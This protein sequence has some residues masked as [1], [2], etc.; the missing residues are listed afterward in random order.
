MNTKIGLLA[1]AAFV[2][3]A[4]HAAAD[5]TYG[6]ASES[7]Y[8]DCSAVSAGTPCAGSG[9]GQTIQAAVTTG[10][11]L[12]AANSDLTLSGQTMAKPFGEAGTVTV[13]NTGSYARSS[14]DFT[15]GMNLPTI[16]ASTF[17][18][19]GSQDRMNINTIAYQSYDY[20]GPTTDFALTA[21]LNVDNAS[22]SGQPDGVPFDVSTLGGTLPGGAV[23]TD[24]V[25]IWDITALG[26]LT[27]AQPFF[28]TDFLAQCGQTGVLSVG[29]SSGTLAAGASS[30]SVSTSLCAGVPGQ[31]GPNFQIHDGDEILVVAGLQLPVD[32]GGFAD[33]SHTFTTAL[34]TTDLSA[35][36]IANLRAG[37]VSGES[38]LPEPAAWAMMMMGFFGLG[39]VLRGRRAALAL[40][41]V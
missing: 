13:P 8:R 5:P 29:T 22:S 28:D 11:A 21:T 24:Y 1:A 14:V 37:L 35:S 41:A 9:P 20:S 17:S 38:L 27:T 39:S 33:A 30:V 4:G 25:A 18:A 34:D 32:R 40:L 36:D 12:A 19:P 10:G 26:G 15:S 3:A 23:Y 6:S 31:P 2:L 7:T 16:H